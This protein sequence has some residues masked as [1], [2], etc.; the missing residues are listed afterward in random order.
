MS[1]S[2]TPSS[3]SSADRT[4]KTRQ[5]LGMKGAQPGETN[6]WKIRLQLMKPITWIPLIWGVV[7]G[8]ASSGQY[9]WSLEH[10]LIA[11]ACMLL[12]GPL[13]A[14][15]TQTINDFYDRDIDAINEPYRPI[16]SGAI[17]IPQVVTQ[18]TVLLA[19]GIAL[20]YVL[21]LWAG[22]SFPTI[23]VLAIGGS[24]LSYIYSAPPLKLKKNGWLGNYALGAS[25]I[26]L[27][28]WAGHALFGDLNWKIVVLTLFYSL[29]GLGIAVVNDFK[30]VE[31]DR[32]LGLK[33]LP[34]MFG[35][36]TAAWICVLMIDVF[37]LGVAGY[38]MAIQ[39]NLYAVLLIL[40]VIPQI[41]FQDMYFLRDPLQNDVKYQA[42]AQ[43]FL[44]LGM[45][46][47]ALALGHALV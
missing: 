4:A 40:L 7:C 33:S 19:G 30:S 36:S 32:Q 27:P 34:V 3:E 45:L 31:G 23:T 13:L 9:T 42:S 29:A 18:I 41:T 6:L 39:Q 38:L 44:V 24:F 22:H 26:A 43:P 12:S 20:A 21:D 2:T 35:V 28:W 16:P 8:A 47:T 25:Y 37:Q 15:Y 5:L 17:S 1:E 11:A 46:V 10:V 14:G